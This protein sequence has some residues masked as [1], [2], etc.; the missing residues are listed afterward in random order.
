MKPLLILCLGNEILADDAF[1][2]HVAEALLSD[3]GPY[4][5]TD[6]EFAPIAGF[7]LLDMIV[8]RKAV[9]IVD[10]IITGDYEP[11]HLYFIQMGYNVPTTTLVSS[12]QISLPVALQFGKKM[13]LSMP[14]L[15]DVLAVEAQDLYT[16]T[17]SMSKPVEKAVEKAVVRING[18]IKVKEHELIIQQKEV[19][20][21]ANP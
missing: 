18:W 14:E 8:D 11:G 21:N 1:G 17:E 7:S 20:L 5:N 9:L 10:T 2:F 12:H 4:D 15:I 3:Y 16:L 6:I 19:L 13:G